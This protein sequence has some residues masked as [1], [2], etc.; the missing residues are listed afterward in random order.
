M[1][2]FYYDPKHKKTLTHYDR[3]PL[4][5][6]IHPMEDGFIGMNMHYLGLRERA[7]LMDRLYE[8]SSND[9]YDAKTKLRVTYNL[10][11]GAAKYKYFQPTVHRYLKDHVRSRFL[12]IGAAEWDVALFLPVERFA[13]MQKRAVWAQSRKSWQ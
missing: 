13:K 1:F 5:F 10:L 7:V 2:M 4:V 8:L 12:E 11:K 6:P 3:F 9:R